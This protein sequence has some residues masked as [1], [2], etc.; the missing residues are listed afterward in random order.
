MSVMTLKAVGQTNK[1]I[2]SLTSNDED[3]DDDDENSQSS[4][5]EKF[6]RD[7]LKGALK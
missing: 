2:N 6:I 1:R 5:N 7:F 3:D 4:L